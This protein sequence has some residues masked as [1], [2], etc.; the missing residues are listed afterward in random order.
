MRILRVSSGHCSYPLWARPYWGTCWVSEKI[1]LMINREQNLDSKIYI[2]I[3]S[4]WLPVVS[5][6]TITI[7]LTFIFLAGKP[8]IN[9]LH[10]EG[11]LKTKWENTKLCMRERCV[12]IQPCIYQC[13]I[14]LLIQEAST[15][16]IATV[17][18]QLEKWGRKITTTKTISLIIMLTAAY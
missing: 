15:F 7:P 8:S 16:Q 11:A 3:P 2:W 17:H 1:G 10:S 6:D 13:N 18:S 4:L 12:L 14:E 9:N 5:P